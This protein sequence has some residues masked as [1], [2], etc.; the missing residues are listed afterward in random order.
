MSVRGAAASGRIIGHQSVASARLVSHKVRATSRRLV[1]VGSGE[2]GI[3]GT[4]ERDSE[5][6][7]LKADSLPF[8]AAGKTVGAVVR[9][10]GK[11]TRAKKELRKSIRRAARMSDSALDNVIDASSMILDRKSLLRVKPYRNASIHV[12]DAVRQTKRANRQFRLAHSRVFGRAYTRMLRAKR[13][14]RDMKDASRTVRA[15]AAALNAVRNV[16][17]HVAAV[18]ASAVMSMVTTLLAPL[19]AVIAV[20]ALVVSLLSVVSNF[21]GTD[22][23]TVGN[24][25]AEYLEDVLRAGSVC[26][27]V[28]PQVIAAQLEAESGFN[29]RASSG[30]GAQGIA[31]FM[32]GTWSS[33]GKDGDGDGKA[34]V[35]NAHDAIYSQ[36]LYMCELAGLVEHDLQGGTL[37]GDQLALT[38]A[39][40]N[41]GIGNVER[42]HGVP[43]IG[44]TRQYVE[45]I[46]ERMSY[47]TGMQGGTIQAGEVSGKLG[48]CAERQAFC[49]GHATG[50]TVGAV[51]YPA[52]NCTL[53]AYQRRVALGLPVGSYMGNGADWANTARRLGYTVN[54]TPAP[55]AVMVFG[56]GTRVSSWFADPLYGH[57]AIVERVN[58]DGSVYVSEGGTGFPTFPYYET[59]RNATS[60]EFIHN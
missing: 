33:H 16:V 22:T 28:T 37:V 51:G 4:V 7:A 39:A 26:P 6:L 30:A 32:P 60:Y 10:R 46:T 11:H 31:Q 12:R 19:L 14:Y 3:A 20:F 41:A 15:A 21:F 57:V 13:A 53:W 36:G 56:R 38:L 54:H 48:N 44:E 40:Y 24:V 8:K 59:I 47:Y 25:P 2:T 29:P 27:T 34:D 52:R 42:A 5:R 1:A 18:V 58:A 45:R 23:A 9:Q 35:W 17:V 43:A 50:N 49:Y 55:G